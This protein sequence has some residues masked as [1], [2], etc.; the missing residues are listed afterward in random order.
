MRLGHSVLDAHPNQTCCPRSK[1][2][3]SLRLGRAARFYWTYPKISAKQS[4]ANRFELLWDSNQGW[5]ICFE[6]LW[7]WFCFELFASSCFDNNSV[8]SYLLR[9][10]S[11]FISTTVL[12]FDLD[13][14]VGFTW[15]FESIWR[16]QSNNNVLT[17]QR[18]VLPL[19]QLQYFKTR[20]R[21][22]V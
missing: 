9:V 4:K 19:F 18:P 12:L 8:L 20:Y 14:I 11:S 17:D 2:L 5:A 13:R 10:A 16:D 22:K 3:N 6:L 15:W 21:I 7:Q 1:C